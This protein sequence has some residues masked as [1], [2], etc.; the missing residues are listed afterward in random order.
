MRSLISKS[1]FITE[2]KFVRKLLGVGLLL[3]LLSSCCSSIPPSYYDYEYERDYKTGTIVN[4]LFE[5]VLPT[6]KKPAVL[7]VTSF[8]Q[9]NDF[10]KT[11]RFGLL[12]SEQLLSR[13]AGKG[14]ILKETRMKDIFY[15]GQNGEFVLSRKFS[16]VARE[17]DARLVLV[18]TYLEAHNHVLVN[19]RLVDFQ[20][21]EVVASYG[22]QLVKTPDITELLSN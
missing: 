20:T 4:R 18:G 1:C 11:S 2:R 12:M 17:L 5:Q 13:M 22:C 8:V 3:L 15:Q 6:I 21:R 10:S 7:V 9:L 16:R 14:F 19:A